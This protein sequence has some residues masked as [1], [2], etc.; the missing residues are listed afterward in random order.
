MTEGATKRDDTTELLARSR[1]PLGVRFLKFGAVGASGVVIN[2]SVF[3]LG[4]RLVFSELDVVLA[5]N[6]SAVLGFIVSVLSNFVLN[7]VWTWADRDKGRR[8]DFLRRLRSYYVVASAALLVQ[9][10][11]LNALSYLLGYDEPRV[12]LWNLLGIGA[13]MSLN[14]FLNHVWTFRDVRRTSARP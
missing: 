1:G 9:A 5:T 8:V 4:R 10:G 2:M 11:V 3:W 12:Y 6:I 14:F 13:G 7:D